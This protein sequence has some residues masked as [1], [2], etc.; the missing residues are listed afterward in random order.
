MNV[1]FNNN[2]S[3]QHPDVRSEP[4]TQMILTADGQWIPYQPPQEEL[5]P[6]DPTAPSSPSDDSPS[7]DTPPETIAPILWGAG[8]AGGVVLAGGLTFILLRKKKK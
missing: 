1:I 4:G 5:T 8:I 7:P 3:P 2:G 6:T